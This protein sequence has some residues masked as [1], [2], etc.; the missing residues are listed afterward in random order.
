MDDDERI[1]QALDK[2][3]EAATATKARLT[4]EEVFSRIWK[5]LLEK[6]K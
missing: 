1:E 6:Q 4:A 3:H 5:T 2:A